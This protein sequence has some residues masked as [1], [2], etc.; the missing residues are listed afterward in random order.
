MKRLLHIKD[1]IDNRISYYHGLF[2]LLALPFDR[3]YSELILIS[4][5]VHTVL[6]LKKE[7]LKNISSRLLILQ[8]V[9]FVTLISATYA[10]S[11]ARGFDVVSKQLGILLFPLLFAITAP[12]IVKYRSRLLLGFSLG[13]TCT[14]AYLFI[15]ALR[16]IVYY[17]LPVKSLFS[18]AFINHNFSLPIGMHATYLSMLLVIA[19]VYLLQELFAAHPKKDK[20]FMMG[21]LLVLLAG[22]L[23]LSSKS[24]LFSLLLIVNTAFPFF[25]IQKENRRRFFLISLSVSAL[26]VLF[27]LSVDVFR[28]RYMNTLKEDLYQNTAV[29]V[30]NSRADR[31]NAA[32][33]LIKQ[34]PV[35]GTGSGSEIPLLKELYFERKMYVSYLQS[36]NVHNQYLSFLINSGA[37]GLI[38][39]LFTLYWGFRQSFKT[40]DILF[41]SFMVLVAVVSF[42]EDILDVNKGIFFYSFFF[43]FFVLMKRNHRIHLT[44]KRQPRRKIDV[45]NITR[46]TMQPEIT[47]N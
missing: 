17:H 43:S 8:S 9:F 31:W 37:I 15:D 33:D 47:K 28:N 38:V 12:G 7:T 6:F 24:V 39:Y 13:C 10:I 22:L 40:R 46:Q 21:C 42:S 41:F 29:V 20:Q 4:F 45:Y 16:V 2:F 26:L 32:I 36:L 23:Q 27:I 18:R 34:S 25:A 30:Q 1:S 3:F 19:M 44:N 11:V 5:L 35:A 14:I